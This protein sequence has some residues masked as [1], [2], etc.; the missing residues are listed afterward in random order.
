MKDNEE[1]NSNNLASLTASKQEI[2]SKFTPQYLQFHGL[3]LGNFNELKKE[4]L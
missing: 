2:P 3:S 4:T 1:P